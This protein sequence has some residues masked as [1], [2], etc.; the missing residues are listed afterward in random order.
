[1]GRR[2]AGTVTVAMLVLL[3]ALPMAALAHGDE[4]LG[5]GTT[6]LEPGASL[7]ATGGLHYHR[8]AAVVVA[9]GPVTVELVRDATGGVAAS[10]GP[11]TTIR[12]NQLVRCCDRGTWDDHT[13]VVT[14]TG[15]SAARTQVR[16]RLVHDD[17]AVMVDGAESGTRASIVVLGIAWT[18][19]LWRSARRRPHDLPLRS[20]AVRLAVVVGPLVAL[21]LWGGWRYGTGGA[22]G[23]VAG[24][25]DVPVLP[26]NPVVSRATLLVGVG[27]VLWGRAG[28]AWS[29][30]EDTATVG[31]WA[32]GAAIVGSVVAVAVLVTAAYGAGGAAVASAVAAGGPL[33][34]VPTLRAAGAR[35]VTPVP[36]T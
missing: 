23:L 2:R 28:T 20:P 11:A 31:W 7:R 27:L 22:P 13:L 3:L 1:M 12:L 24:L 17:L 4:E 6:V 30:V 15:T 29:R 9:D 33:L 21:A 10:A 36:G 35:T 14:N 25:A 26:F 5:D 18:G 16:A 34:A 32:T 8:L 19:L